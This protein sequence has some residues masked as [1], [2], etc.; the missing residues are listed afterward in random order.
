MRAFLL[1]SRN[2]IGRRPAGA[3]ALAWAVLAGLFLQTTPEIAEAQYPGELSGRVADAITGEPLESV[4]VEVL[5]VGLTALSDGRGEYRIRGLEAGRYTVQFSRLGYE[6]QWQDVEV[7]NGEVS[8]LGVQL[9]ARPLPI[10][11]VRAEAEAGSSP[12]VISISRKEIE[13]RGELTA[14][15]LL[16]GR[17]GL[18]VQRRG[19]AGPQ[20]V[21]IR[22]SS[23]DEVLVLLDGAPLNDPLSGEADLS[24]I[25]ASQIESITV[26]SGS[27]SARYGP[28][29]AA[30]AVLIESRATAPPFG[31]R[32]ET[33]SLGFWSGGVE[34]SGSGL[35]FAWSAGG[36]AR[37][38]DGAFEFQ[39]P[40]ALGG[41]TEVR[42]N[43]DVSEASV[44][45]AAAGDLA[46]GAFRLRAGY[47]QLERGI[48]SPSFSP[49]PTA[50]QDL[51]RWRGQAA[52]ERE[53]GRSSLSLQ[54]HGVMQDMRFSDPNPPIGLP[55]ESR[56]DA[57]VLGGRLASAVSLDGFIESL[58]GGLEL[59]Q[60]RYK[61][62]ALDE[63]APGGRLDFG[64]FLG[65]QLAATSSANSPR[66]VAALRLDHDDLAGT[67][68]ATH[69]LTLTARAGPAAFYVR[70]ASS[71][72]PPG[73]GDQFFKEGV[74]VEPNP[75]LR[76]ER[77]P[78]DLSAGASIE[79]AIG[80]VA[81]GRLA[82]D[83]YVADVKDMII[84]SPDFRFVWSPRNFNVKRRGFDAEAQLELPPQRLSLSATYSLA[85]ATYDRPGDATVQVI[86]RPRHSGSIT[87]SWRPVRW[88]IAVDARFIGTRYP[89][90]APLNA[91]DPYWTVHLRLR[92]SFDAGSWE[93]VP[94]LA[95]DRLLDS[96]DSLIFGYPEPG[97]VIRF[98]VAARP[99]GH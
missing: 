26:L 17:P 34:T 16:E 10:A 80:T 59:R 25:P 93:I 18:V 71:Y 29:A 44:F 85:R 9:G 46:G 43:A 40:D 53:Q 87:A 99:R 1:P 52:W 23:A 49:T 32:L 13:Q 30:G 3:G 64:V 65:G 74:A 5:G 38:V 91:L 21:S 73:F 84:W 41:G 12:G 63:A 6:P 4:L 90:P 56:T 35:G 36:S 78:N 77:V 45:G 51:T 72:S 42:V 27:Q 88:E 79:G 11:E 28:G 92:R 97:R 19:P 82:V 96:E 54:V 61:S 8:R 66:L 69:E 14:G 57:L 58:S 86:Y 81:I 89:V 76:A 47:T 22:G 24:T 68:Y 33:G 75:D 94:T 67:W 31:A 20:T 50:R 48:P 60:Q 37:T 70:Q 95:V 98:E 7:R 15:G 83:G 62:N 39:R 2:H 55:Y